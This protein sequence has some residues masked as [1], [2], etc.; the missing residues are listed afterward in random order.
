MKNLSK[1]K[2]SLEKKDFNIGLS[3]VRDW[4]STGNSGLNNM[5][6]QDLRFSIPVGRVSA[7]AGLQGSGKS[8]IIANIIKNA[9]EKGYFAIYLDTEYATSD[10]FMEKIGVDLDED[11]F[12]AVN[13]ALVEEVT[14]F[15]SELL[16]STDK[17]D[18]IIFVVDSLSN[19]QMK[20]DADKFE[21]GEQ[22]YGQGLRE[23]MLK[24]LVTNMNSKCGDRDMAIVFTSHM[25][26]SGM[27]NYGNAILKPNIG[28][29]TLFLPSV[30]VQLSKKEL[31]ENREA[32]G[33]Q[34]TAKN[35]KSRFAMTGKTCE[36][37][38]PWD[39]G[40]NF[41]DGSLQVLEEHGVVDKNGGW[42]SYTNKE[43]GEVVK[44][45]KNDYE[46]HVDILMDY[47]GGKEVEIVEKSE[48]DANLE[49]YEDAHKDD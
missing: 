15:F 33:I 9:Q 13:T 2:K 11:K 25:Y 8:F 32:V 42:Y 27:D 19:L 31:K 16:K 18:K 49:Y 28:E 29:G 3:P 14:S 36:F 38:L 46:D 30:V 5:I 6:S 17:E 20:R 24:Q 12:M 35:L 40:M 47:Y 48:I 39:R 4:I 7:F 34:V 23:K 44:F 1:L 26:V 43:T 22:A 10:G 41:L 21:K 45:Q 37:D